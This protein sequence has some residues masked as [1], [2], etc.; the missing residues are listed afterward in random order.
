MMCHPNHGERQGKRGR[1][2]KRN[3]PWS[4]SQTVLLSTPAL[5]SFRWLSIGFHALSIGFLLPGYQ[6]HSEDCV[7]GLLPRVF[8]Q[9][10]LPTRLRED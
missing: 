5:L 9:V 2:K 3:I 8:G 7:L 10:M 6:E 1:T 4:P